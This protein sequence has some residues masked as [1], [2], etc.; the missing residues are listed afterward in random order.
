[1]TNKITIFSEQQLTGKYCLSP[2]VQ[3]NIDRNGDVGL[4]GCSQWQPTSIGSIFEHSLQDLL[5]NATAQ[6][7]RKSIID[8]TYIYCDTTK[9][10]VIRADGLNSYKT[11]PDKVKWAVKD[12]AR[13]SMPRHIVLAIDNTCNLSCPSCRHHVIKNTQETEQRQLELSKILTK[14]LFGTPTDDRVELTLD[15]SGEVFAS[16]LLLDFINGISPTDFPNIEIDI[17]SN[18]LLAKDRWHRLGGMQSYVKQITISYDSS[19]PA[20]YEKLRRGG[21]FDRLVENLTWLG[22]KKK[23]NGMKFKVRMVVQQDNFT[24][25][26]EFYDFS[27]TVNVDE[28][29]YQRIINWGTYKPTEFKD[30]D[31]FDPNSRQYSHAVECF[32]QVE[33]LPNTVFWHGFPT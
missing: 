9:C 31:V 21:Q 10:G 16:P 18:G 14:N 11:L 30:I 1:M 27:Q 20:T 17:L 29:Q 4:C 7:I 28:V 33:Q 5:A 3:V 24:Q 8:G 32:K 25:M 19:D 15:T 6:N 26:K 13:F 22:N 2:F 23:E 12:H